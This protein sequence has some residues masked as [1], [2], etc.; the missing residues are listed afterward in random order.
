MISTHSAYELKPGKA[1]EDFVENREK[2]ATHS[3]LM[4]DPAQSGR[5]GPS[6]REGTGTE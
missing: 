2:V 5:P 3:G 1:E 6:S 4:Q